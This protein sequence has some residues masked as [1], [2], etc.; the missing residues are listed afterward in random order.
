MNDENKRKLV[1]TV[2]ILTGIIF[3]ANLLTPKY[4]TRNPGT[5]YQQFPQLGNGHVGRR[6]AGSFIAK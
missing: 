2:L 5:N 3:V 1:R 4:T 6:S